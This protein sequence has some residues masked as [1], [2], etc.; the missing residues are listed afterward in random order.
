[1]RIKRQKEWKHK[2]KKLKKSIKKRK[3]ES[4]K[5]KIKKN[6]YL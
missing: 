3:S 6:S 4:T 1:M 2:S 5:F